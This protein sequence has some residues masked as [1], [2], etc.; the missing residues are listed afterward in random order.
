MVIRSDRVLLSSDH[1]QVKGDIRFEHV[2]FAYEPDKPV[3]RDL[4][5]TRRRG[6]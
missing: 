6:R 5:F 3:L 2:S 4:S 1:D